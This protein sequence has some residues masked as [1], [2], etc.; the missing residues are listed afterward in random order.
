MPLTLRDATPADAPAICDIWNP[1][2][3]DTVITFNPVLRSVAEVAAMITDRQAANWA[4]IVA[5]TAGQV[6][7]FATYAQFRAGQGYARCMEHTI[8]LA[9]Q[10]RGSG[11]GAALLDMIE[12]HARARA[13][14]VM[15]AAITGDNS[16]SIRFHSARGY[17]HVGT[18]PEVGWK[19][20]RAH[21]LYLM[22]K[23]LTSV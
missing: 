16:P 11:A 15:V 17:V 19:F 21:D 2:I 4:F 18:M 1:I 20:G 13:Y 8:N 3:R 14:H 12:E 6:V 5:E 23:I 9:P 7:G 22:Q 10:A